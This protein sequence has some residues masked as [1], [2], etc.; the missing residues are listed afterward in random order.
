MRW[1]KGYRRTCP[2]WSDERLFVESIY[3]PK[4]TRVPSRP[5]GVAPVPVDK[6]VV[7]EVWCR[8]DCWDCLVRGCVWA[9][10]YEWGFRAIALERQGR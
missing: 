10:S 7:M 9:A 5:V 1:G 2:K 8:E 4:V 3:H 6:P